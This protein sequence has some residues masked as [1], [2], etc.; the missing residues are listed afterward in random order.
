MMASWEGDL[1]AATIDPEVFALR[2]GYVA[3]LIVARGL[4][5]G[6]PSVASEEALCEAETVAAQ[7]LEGVEAHDLPTIAEWRSAFAAF[8]VKPR[9]ARSSAEA[10]LRRV[11]A[12]LPRID[13]LT[14]IY[15]A[16]SVI[17]QT[18]IGG[19]D[20]TGYVGAPR[21]SVAHG[22]ETF[23]T[24][25][26]GEPTAQIASAGEVIWR[27]AVGVTCRRWN[28]R[29]CVRTRLTARTTDALFI[30]DALGSDAPHRATA[31][32]DDLARR[33]VIDSPECRRRPRRTHSRSW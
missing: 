20:L 26:N 14:D 32:A 23:D 3:V 11:G 10:L 6:D 15:N 24:M 2:P 13:R 4:V 19:E 8:G 25:A 16:V 1:A 28:W 17:H 29:Q 9:E 12:G 31:A 7:A 5:P 33:L 30:I 21:L 18:P 27:D 22:D